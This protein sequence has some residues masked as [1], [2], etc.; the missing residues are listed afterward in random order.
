M[1]QVE[2]Q[3][4]EGTTKDLERCTILVSRAE[5]EHFMELLFFMETVLRM[6]AEATGVVGAVVPFP[7][8]LQHN[9]MH[10]YPDVSLRSIGHAQRKVC[11]GLGPPSM[12]VQK[13]FLNVGTK[14]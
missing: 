5:T 9:P 6:S 4:L 10:V 7:V 13:S 3:Q 2:W 11:I 12:H 1:E 8:G 14:T